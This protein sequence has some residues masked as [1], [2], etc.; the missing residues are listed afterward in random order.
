MAFT[1]YAILLTSFFTLFAVYHFL[2][3]TTRRHLPP[4]P[5]PLFLIGNI[6]QLGSDHPEV[7][8]QKFAAKYGS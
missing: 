4:G 7:L 2:V 3:A 5:R 6:R 8:F 1:H